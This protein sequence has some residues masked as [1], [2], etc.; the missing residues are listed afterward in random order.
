[1]YGSC[2]QKVHC[3][4][5]ESRTRGDGDEAWVRYS[6]PGREI[7]NEIRGHLRA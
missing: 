3:R 4:L 6:C 2:A 7:E 1:M 5:A